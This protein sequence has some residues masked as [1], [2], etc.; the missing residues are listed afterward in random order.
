MGFRIFLF[1]CEVLDES[2]FHL[3][4]GQFIEVKDSFLRL[5]WSRL[6]EGFEFDS[7]FVR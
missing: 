7:V 5:E 1:L 3:A 2:A 4:Y 6:D